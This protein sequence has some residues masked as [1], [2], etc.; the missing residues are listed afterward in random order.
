METRALSRLGVVPR[1]P[2]NRREPAVHLRRTSNG[3]ASCCRETVTWSRNFCKRTMSR[4]SCGA[5]AAFCLLMSGPAFGSEAVWLPG[6]GALGAGGPSPLSTDP[7]PW[8][9]FLA[10]ES[11]N[12]D[13]CGASGGTGLMSF[14]DSRGV[15]KWCSFVF[16]NDGRSGRFR[17]GDAGRRLQ[18]R[19]SED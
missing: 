12:R 2:A 7:S 19:A 16:V 4:K 6:V 9:Q 10:E 8:Y 17:I 18:H 3:L 14:Q 13:S 1:S 15:M 5:A 11:R